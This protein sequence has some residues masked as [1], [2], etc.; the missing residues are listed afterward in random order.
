MGSIPEIFPVSGSVFRG[1]DSSRRTT[2]LNHVVRGVRVKMSK[3][4]TDVWIDAHIIRDITFGAHN[5]GPSNYYSE[6]SLEFRKTKTPRARIITTGFIRRHTRNT[7][8]RWTKQSKRFFFFF[9]GGTRL[10]ST[11]R[12]CNMHDDVPAKPYAYRGIN[13][14]SRTYYAPW[15]AGW[16]G[17]NRFSRFDRRI[18][19]TSRA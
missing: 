4:L 8:K 1:E 2:T 15:N 19:R 7:P 9:L 17:S 16:N 11:M 3:S 13:Y 14:D 5:F 12:Y 10:I 18:V 6:T